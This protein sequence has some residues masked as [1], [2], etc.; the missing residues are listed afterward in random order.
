MH[1][2]EFVDPLTIRAVTITN[3]YSVTTSGVMF[4]PTHP[5]K[6]VFLLWFTTRYLGNVNGDY[7]YPANL[8]P[9][10]YF[11]YSRIPTYYAYRPWTNYAGTTIGVNTTYTSNARYDATPIPLYLWAIGLE[12]NFLLA[13]GD[14][15]ATVWVNLHYA[16]IK[17]GLKREKGYV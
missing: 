1:I 14:T 4:V 8:T 2:P 6:D 9:L 16:Y 15:S 12:C 10:R 13:S 11:I 7:I 3:T 5:D 17:K